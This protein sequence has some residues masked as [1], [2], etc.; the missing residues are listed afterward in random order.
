MTPRDRSADLLVA[1]N[2]DTFYGTSHILRAARLRVRSGEAVSLLGRN[3]MGKTT[4]LR[5]IAGLVKPRQGRITFAGREIGGWS[6]SAISRTGLALAPEGRG[7]FRNL[8]V[9]ENLQLALRPARAGAARTMESVYAMF[10]R[11]A[12]RRRNWGDQLSGGEAQMLTIGRA[13]LTNPALLMID[14]ATEGLAPKVRDEIWATLARIRAEGVAV[15]VVDKNIDDLLALCD[16]H[17]ILVKG[18]VV[19]EGTS[20]QLRDT[21]DLIHTHLGV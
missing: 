7:I 1:E 5:T 18:E 8:T 6:A 10:P 12:E 17:T 14:E 20:A 19:F 3:G 11:L 13:L 16:R 4:F 2:V 15:L 9:E 21:P